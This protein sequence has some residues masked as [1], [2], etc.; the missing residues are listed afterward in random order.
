MRAAASGLSPPTLPPAFLSSQ[1][2][3]K[4]FRTE[5]R[6]LWWLLQPLDPTLA[7]YPKSSFQPFRPF[8]F[9][10]SGICLDWAF[11]Y[12]GVPSNWDTPFQPFLY[13]FLQAHTPSPDYSPR[14]SLP[15]KVPSDPLGLA[16]EPPLCF[17][18]PN[19]S[20][21]EGQT[22]VGIGGREACLFPPLRP[23]FKSILG[24][25]IPGA[26]F[27]QCSAS[28][29]GGSTTHHALVGWYKLPP[30]LLRTNTCEPLLLWVKSCAKH[31]L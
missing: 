1:P 15:L 13:C 8:W 20:S 22:P 28:P 25:G 7:P 6:R 31:F 9:L 3:L 2:L 23:L 27:M 10:E 29:Q 26:T 14:N 21:E 11:S 5:S 18:Q 19:S 12:T 17:L 30:G 4:M 16:W 24:V